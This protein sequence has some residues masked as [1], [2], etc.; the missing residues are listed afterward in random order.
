MPAESF[1]VAGYFGQ[2]F[3]R[4]L[5]R[6]RMHLR[7]LHLEMSSRLKSGL[8]TFLGKRPAPLFFFSQTCWGPFLGSSIVMSTG[9]LI[10]WF[11]R[12]KV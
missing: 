10:G 11:V 2:G 4:H 6:Q 9:G 1:F 3:S 8:F 7:D 12:W 5:I